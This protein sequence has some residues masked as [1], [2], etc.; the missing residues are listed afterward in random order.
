MNGKT[1]ELKDSQGNAFKAYLSHPRGGRG[2]GVV[3]G[4]DIHGL[5]PL[6]HEIADLFAE[7]GYLTIVPDY[8]WDVKRGE[9]GSF[10]TTLKM[11]TCIEVVKTSLGELKKMPECNGKTAVVGYCLG[12]N[13]AYMGVARFGADAAAS[14]Y[15]T[16]IHTLLDEVDAIKKP[17]LL[18][19]AEH[20]HTHS[21]EERDKILATVKKNR[22]I[23]PHVYKGPHGFASSTFTKED[24][25]LANQRTFALF[26]TLK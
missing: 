4:L 22:Q 8:F 16:R 18:H 12:G 13:L 21:D 5:R 2:P 3:M 20:D 19:I 11:P 9:D 7:Q 15:G 6:Y 23:T 14:Y 17:L 10:R 26:D 25:D 24:A 1:I